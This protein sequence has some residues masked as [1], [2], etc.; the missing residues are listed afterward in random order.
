MSLIEK[1]LGETTTIS[2]ASSKFF[3]LRTTVPSSVVKQW[4][5]QLGD[6]LD[7]TWDKVGDK[8]VIILTKVEGN[9]R[10]Q[11]QPNMKEVKK[12]AK[13][14]SSRVSYRGLPRRK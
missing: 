1:E 8:M 2:K 14:V 6:K 7:W 10:P 11:Q 12:F 9:E 4:R 5:L 3:S 13:E